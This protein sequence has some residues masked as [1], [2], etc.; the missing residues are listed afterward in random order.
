MIVYLVTALSL[1]AV[2]VPLVASV[3]LVFR[4]SGVVNFGAGNVAAFAAAACAAWSVQ[5]NSLVGAVLTVLAGAVIGLAT[6]YIAILPAQKR[7]VSVISLT[8]AT[9]GVG[10]LLNFANR[11]V[12]GGDPTV[13]Q[14]WIPGTVQIGDF[15]TATQRF[16]VIGL[17]ILLLAVLWFVF[18][19]TLMGRVLT[20][21]SHDRELASMYGVRAGR[22]ELIAWVV[23]GMCLVIG[24]MF[25]AS[26]ASV[27][28][29][30]SP[31]LLVFSLVGAVIGGLDNLFTAVGGAV[32]AGFAVTLTDQLIAPGYQL[33]T[34]F[35]VLTVVLLIRPHGLFAF[36][37]TAE[38]V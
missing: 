26:L 36:R 12:F 15:Q 29:E 7:G 1:A 19:R 3:S 14:P 25:Q 34:L 10:L 32:V 8:I 22:Y 35:V 37:G 31:T 33:V 13:I 28:V 6:Y 4:V 2:L 27:S 18:D 11:Q 30:V 24:G 21:V 5:T 16:V 38:R 17:A 9:L 20:A 23:S